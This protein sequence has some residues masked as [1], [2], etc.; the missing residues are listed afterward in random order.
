MYFSLDFDSKEG[1]LD[2]QVFQDRFNKSNKGGKQ[3]S[4]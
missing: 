3:K 4:K 1:K 2:K